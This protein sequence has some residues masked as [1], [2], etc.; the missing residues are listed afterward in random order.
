MLYTI[1]ITAT[2]D[3]E[4]FLLLHKIFISSRVAYKYL[5]KLNQIDMVKILSDKFCLTK[6]EAENLQHVH[7][8]VEPIF[9]VEEE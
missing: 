2:N 3:T 7:G 5:A 6:E 8:N 1:S 4:N 9:N